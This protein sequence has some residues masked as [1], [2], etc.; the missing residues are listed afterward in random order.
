MNLVSKQ[1]LVKSYLVGNLDDVGMYR[2]DHR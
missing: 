2:M 1:A